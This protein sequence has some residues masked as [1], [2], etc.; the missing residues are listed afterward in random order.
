MFAYYMRVSMI[1]LTVY[2][3]PKPLQPAQIEHE[4]KSESCQSRSSQGH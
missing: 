1:D 3:D 2:F 4:P